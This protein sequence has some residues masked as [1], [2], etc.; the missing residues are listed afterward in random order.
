MSQLGT[1]PN[2]IADENFLMNIFSENLTEFEP[3]REYWEVTF[4]KKQVS[5]VAQCHKDRTKVVH[6]SRLQKEL[7]S[8]VSSTNVR[9]G[10]MLISLA[11]TA[12]KAI[13]DEL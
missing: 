7:F 9:T 8:P 6:M 12:A 1:L 13:H 11:N 4:E 5:V 3:F 2:L 10:E